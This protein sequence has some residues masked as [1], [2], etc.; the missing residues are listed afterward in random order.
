MVHSGFTSSSIR[1]KWKFQFHCAGNFKL[2]VVSG[3]DDMRLES[4]WAI[5]SHLTSL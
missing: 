5:V 3:G 2:A 1:V 4:G